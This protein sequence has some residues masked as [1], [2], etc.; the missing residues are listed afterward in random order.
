MPV[1]YLILYIFKNTKAGIISIFLI[2]SFV[3]SNELHQIS[4]KHN[5]LWNE[6]SA[7]EP[8]VDALRQ[9]G[10]NLI[11]GQD[12]ALQGSAAYHLLQNAI[13]QLSSRL[14][15]L[16]VHHKAS[17]HN[18]HDLAAQIDRLLG[19]LALVSL[20][21]VIKCGLAMLMG[22]LLHLKM[23]RHFQSNNFNSI[24]TKANFL[25]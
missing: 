14:P 10:M 8:S 23:Q 15:V 24:L 25:R 3:W 4:R 16:Q 12:T 9:R 6:I 5:C 2:L 11:R 19:N 20:T 1:L 21:D 18:C 22:E 7:W 17:Q 13:Q